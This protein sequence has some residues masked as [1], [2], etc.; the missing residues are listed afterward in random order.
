MSFKEFFQAED[1]SPAME[2][3]DWEAFNKPL[4]ELPSV[5]KQD[6]PF[7]EALAGVYEGAVKP[8]VEGISS[9]F[10]IAMA[11]LA[12]EKEVAHI[13]A[14]LLA[15]F[16]AYGGVQEMSEAEKAEKAGDVRGSARHYSAALSDML[17]GIGI[18]KATEG[19]KY[20]PGRGEEAMLALHASPYNF[21]KFDISHLG[22]GEGAQAFGHG[23]YFSDIDNPRINEHY[24]DKFTNRD[25]VFRNGKFNSEGWSVA[26]SE[27][28]ESDPSHIASALMH[29]YGEEGKDPAKASNYA[30]M[31]ASDAEMMTDDASIPVNFNKAADLIDSGDVIQLEGMKD[32]RAINYKADLPFEKEDL[33]HWE[34]PLDQQPEMVKKSISSLGIDDEFLKKNPTGEAIYT[35]LSQMHADPINQTEGWGNINQSLWRGDELIGNEKKASQA[36]LKNGIPGIAYYDSNSRRSAMRSN[37]NQLFDTRPTHNVVAFSDEGI[38]I[39]EKRKGKFEK[40]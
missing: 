21:E 32:R 5:G 38:K 14:R 40:E 13:S 2:H 35:K 15:P 28:N 39:L 31:W 3:F 19:G 18:L 26:G 9:P 37:P 8:A 22:K 11:P 24:L 1:D 10:G 30:R 17:G 33:L 29:F 12:S 7:K 4:I 23:L 20:L 27:F 25:P 36:L 34:L 6:T 16:M